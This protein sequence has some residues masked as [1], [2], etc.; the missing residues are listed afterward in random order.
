MD[1]FVRALG[2]SNK[3]K[4][5]DNYLVGLRGDTKAGFSKEVDYGEIDRAV[6]GGN[7][8]RI[9]SS[10]ENVGKQLSDLALAAL[11][12]SDVSVARTSW[13]AYYMQDLRRQG[14][15]I[16]NID[17]ENEHSNPNEEAAAYAEQM[18][19]RSQNA[20]D[21]S[22][23]GNMFKKQS[24]FG[25]F[26]KNVFLPFSS[27]SV[28][29]RVRMTNDMQKLLYGENKSEAARSLVATAA[30]V[31]LFNAVKVYIIGMLTT[32]GAETLAQFIG[33]M[34]EDDDELAKKLAKQDKE[35]KDNYSE[36][37]VAGVK[38]TDKQKKVA[39]Q[40]LSDYFFSGMGS[41]PQEWL[42]QG[43]NYLY[44][45]NVK[46]TLKDGTVNEN[47]RL[48]F[49]PTNT[50]FNW[51]NFGTAGIAPEK[52][53]QMTESAMKVYGG[54][55]YYGKKGKV[56]GKVELTPAEKK[57]YAITMLIDGLSVMGVGDADLSVL[58]QKLK[59]IA[60]RQVEF[61]YGGREFNVTAPAKDKK[62][63]KRIDNE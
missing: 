2:V 58:N 26:V 18:V 52:V 53:Q 4:L 10:L 14:I 38:L 50:G 27:F 1:L 23:L 46:E 40:A 24:G 37:E 41:A 47:A 36:V 31:T 54:A 60:D 8:E 17:W 39:A 13:L 11:T 12:K 29:Q 44:N 62:A 7:Y 33:L 55:D 48:Y 28:N 34:G 61:K 32:L 51:R 15:D 56:L 59:S 9:S 49:T 3:I 5:F 16:S 21:A 20:N 30:E 19:S 45:K 57:A 63:K 42:Q 22:T 25:G 35:R 6:V 43:A